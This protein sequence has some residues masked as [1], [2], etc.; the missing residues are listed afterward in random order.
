M[1][2]RVLIAEAHPATLR[3]LCVLLEAVTDMQLLATVADG[4]AAIER[5]ADCMPDVVLLDSNLSDLPTVEVLRHLRAAQPPPQVLLYS[6][7]P[8]PAYIYPLLD[9]DIAGYVHKTEPLEVLLSALRA[10]ARGEP[11]FTSQ[12]QATVAAWVQ[13]DAA[14][15]PE[16]TTLTERERDVLCYVVQ[17]VNNTAIATQLQISTHTVVR[18]VSSILKKLGCSNRL[19]VVARALQ[20]GWQSRL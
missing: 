1:P 6:D 17:G 14:F 20:E 13:G 9:A 8:A 19:A 11:W 12:V 4:A 7:N 16:I 18:H 2:I 10:V 5:T 15:P 3:G